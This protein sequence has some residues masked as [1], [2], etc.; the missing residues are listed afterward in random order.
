[1][2]YVS[3]TTGGNGFCP[4]YQRFSSHRVYVI[5]LGRGRLLFVK[6]VNYHID[7]F[8]TTY[9]VQSGYIAVIVFW[10]TT[11][12]GLP[13][14]IQTVLHRIIIFVCRAISKY[15]GM[16]TLQIDPFTFLNKFCFDCQVVILRLQHFL[17]YISNL[18]YLILA[19]QN[20]SYL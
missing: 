16:Y 4:A 8:H 17:W 19:Y 20:L 6:H 3:N 18:Y 9:L 1:M 11:P 10:L 7:Y 13:L 15:T 12:Q 2:A 14:I 5:S